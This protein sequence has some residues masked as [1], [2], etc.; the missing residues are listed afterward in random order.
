M[1]V[2]VCIHSTQME[3]MA[4]I[5]N[6]LI[7]MIFVFGVTCYVIL[8]SWIN[9]AAQAALCCSCLLP[10]D[11]MSVPVAPTDSSS[12]ECESEIHLQYDDNDA[13]PSKQARIGERR[14]K[15]DFVI[16]D[17]PQNEILLSP[18]KTKSKSPMSS[19]GKSIHSFH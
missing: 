16:P 3:I 17:S 4:S 7:M 13:R 10:A 5:I 2:C 9:R 12:D 15:D 11:A 6:I 19:R 1:Y 14:E 18:G 8:C